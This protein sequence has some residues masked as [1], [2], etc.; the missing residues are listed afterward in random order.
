MAPFAPVMR[1]LLFIGFLALSMLVPVGL[2][3]ARPE[4][5]PDLAG[6]E[7]LLRSGKADA[8]WKML[9]PHEFALAGREDFDYLL[10]VAALDSG[11]ADRATLIFE[12]VLTVNPDHAAAR[13]DMARAYFALNDFQ[14][15][16]GE[17]EQLMR[18]EDTPPA[19]RQTIERY[20]AA[21]EERT[22][23]RKVR[24]TAYAEAS[25][26][27][28]GNVSGATSSNSIFVPL[29]N[30]NFVL[31]ESSVKAADRFAS[32]GGGAELTRTLG[33]GVSLL[34]GIDLKQ[35]AHR[36]WDAFDSRSI[37]YRLG[38]QAVHGK[39]TFRLTFGRNDYALDHDPYRRIGSIGLELRHAADA[40]MQYIAFA[41][42]SEIKYLQ[43]GSA[44]Y[45]SDQIVAGLGLVRSLGGGGSPIVFGSIYAGDD[46]ATRSRADGD[47]ALLGLRGGY[48]RSLRDGLDAY[49]TLSVQYNRYKGF[50]ALF[51]NERKETQYDVGLGLN[52]RFERDW[53]LK[54]QLNF[55]RADSNFQVYDYRRH[56]F[57]LTLRRDFR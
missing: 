20:L 38:L 13:L 21:I 49:A 57:S 18:H 3:Q 46:I 17:F 16:R 29:F 52:W 28:D 54:P 25:L 8:V 24:L 23:G 56:E 9:S 40:G 15:S 36:Q 42:A 12:R 31:G 47:R 33:E 26:G 22:S 2:A 30:A 1:I 55:T 10:G 50:N 53:T 19:A 34:A 37:D 44:S 48:Q 14:R 39:D 35:R 6:A 41:Q 32:L 45:S 4:A 11:R 7:A 5:P 43:A 27:R 51:Q